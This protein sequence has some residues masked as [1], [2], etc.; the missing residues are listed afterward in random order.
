MKLEKALI[1]IWTSL[2]NLRLE[3]IYKN[4]LENIRTIFY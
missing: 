2:K 4:I 3:N 1:N